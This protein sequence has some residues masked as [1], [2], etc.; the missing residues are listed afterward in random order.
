MLLAAKTLKVDQDDLIDLV[1]AL[2]SA[3]IQRNRPDDAIDQYSGKTVRE[4]ILEEQ[5]IKRAK[6]EEA[7]KTLDQGIAATSPLLFTKDKGLVTKTL[8]NTD[9]QARRGVKK[10]AKDMC[11]SE[12]FY[13]SIIFNFWGNYLQND[14]NQ[15]ARKSDL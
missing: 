4:T 14:I 6:F 12:L 7:K 8:L 2:N 3:D 11:A 13:S 15:K 10:S 9:A 1:L 5:R